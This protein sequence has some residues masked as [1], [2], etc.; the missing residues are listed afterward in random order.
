MGTEYGMGL[1]PHHYDRLSVIATPREGMLACP[2]AEHYRLA[3]EAQIQALRATYPALGVR[4]PWVATTKPVPYI[5]AGKWVI[6]CPCGDYPLASPVWNEARCFACGAIYRK[7]KWPRDREAI[8]AAL[9][10]RPRALLRCWTPGISVRE[11]Q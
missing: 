6:I 1:I 7:L 4:M 3:H 2:T 11:G 10:A 5:T 9:V 8:E